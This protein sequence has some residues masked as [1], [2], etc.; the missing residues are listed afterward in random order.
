M[1]TMTTLIQPYS[2]QAFP[3]EKVLKEFKPVRGM[4][5]AG[6]IDIPAEDKAVL[7]NTALNRYLDRKSWLGT[8]LVP[9]VVPVFRLIAEKMGYDLP[10]LLEG[11]GE[12][13]KPSDTWTVY[14]DKGQT[15]M[16]IRWTIGDAQ[17]IL[18][19]VVGDENIEPD[20]AVLL[21]SDKQAQ[22]YLDEIGNALRALEEEFTPQHLV[23]VPDGNV[24][25][26]HLSGGN[27]WTEFSI[28]CRIHVSPAHPMSQGRLADLAAMRNSAQVIIEEGDG[29]GIVQHGEMM[30]RHTEG[31]F[32]KRCYA[33]EE[34]ISREFIEIL[35]D[36][37]V[38][39]VEKEMEKVFSEHFAL[40]REITEGAADVGKD[41][42]AAPTIDLEL[43]ERAARLALLTSELS[44]G[45]PNL[46]CVS[47]LLQAFHHRHTLGKA[48]KLCPGSVLRGTGS[49][50]KMEGGDV[51]YSEDL[52]AKLL[53]ALCDLPERY[54]AKGK[55]RPKVLVSGVLEAPAVAV[56]YKDT[57]PCRS[58]FS[59]I[60][61]PFY[62]SHR[63]LPVRV[64][65]S[66]AVWRQGYDTEALAA[67]FFY[68]PETKDL[69]I[70]NLY[71]I[72]VPKG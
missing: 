71:R 27:L 52:I 15:P 57:V 36:E 49:D 42:E 35:H 31:F 3:T 33:A 50:L 28:R 37:S 41:Q 46:P 16:L 40:Q 66:V 14:A 38:R 34:T 5:F 4:R 13:G 18:G 29:S 24:L 20:L 48:F 43:A 6:P 54:P 53:A 22:A 45:P 19:I 56:G 21:L 11:K 63:G 64:D 70:A 10:S 30:I 67:D 32:R 69:H 44:G 17:L 68:A 1:V 7:R 61:N 62:A 12:T 8:R 2:L 60:T 65:K 59:A 55:S 72:K 23:D 9:D 51:T 39:D 58:K 25:T 47:R 26:R